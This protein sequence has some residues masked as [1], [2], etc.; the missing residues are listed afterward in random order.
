MDEPLD[1][2]DTQSIQAEPKNTSENTQPIEAA[3]Q[4]LPAWILAWAEKEED[5]TPKASLFP[6]ETESEEPFIAPVMDEEDAWAQ[7]ETLLKEPAETLDD[8]LHA[9]DLSRAQ[10]WIDAHKN[11]P[12]FRQSASKTIRKHLSL[13]ENMSQLWDIYENLNED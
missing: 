10:K 4:P 13:D 12:E 1:A 8:I 5:L 11:E 9:G 2:Q 6:P 7:E 3:T